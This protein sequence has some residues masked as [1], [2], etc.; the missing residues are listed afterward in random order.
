MLKEYVTKAV[1]HP[2]QI[3]DKPNLSPELQKN[4]VEKTHFAFI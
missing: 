2:L 3:L 1:Q 4:A